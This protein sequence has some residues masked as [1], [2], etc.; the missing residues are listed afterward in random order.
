MKSFKSLHVFSNGS[1]YIQFNLIKK[2]NKPIFKKID[3]KNFKFNQKKI[4]NKNPVLPSINY[5]KK[6][7]KF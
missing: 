6:Y 2:S 4:V 7:N 5:K 1:C 3:D